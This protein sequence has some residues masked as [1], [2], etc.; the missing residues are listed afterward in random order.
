MSSK[1]VSMKEKP[2]RKLPGL[3]SV[4]AVYFFFLSA[5]ARTFIEAGET[6]VVSTMVMMEA[7]FI[8][9]MSAV[10]WIRKLPAWLQH[11]LLVFQVVLVVTIQQ[12][13]PED[14]FAN[15]LF[16]L[17]S[18]QVALIFHG[19]VL[20]IWIIGLISTT[21]ISLTIAMGGL[22]GLSKSFTNIAGEVAIFAYFIAIR[23]M[24]DARERR[25]LAMEELQ[26]VHNRLEEYAGQVNE[27]SAVNERN[28][29]ARELHDSVSQTLFSISLNIRTVQILFKK[30]PALTRE[31]L[32]RL[33][34]LT[35][36]ALAE[37]RSL[38][39]QMRPQAK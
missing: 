34:L 35:E 20:A 36:N 13:T 30:N 2:T 33:Q 5:V 4:I 38:I 12:L 39:T 21:C 16:V 28:R 31:P 29:L 10:I 8:V 3:I 24:D 1:T 11:L 27:L 9:C 23:E 17:I 37:I 32:H 19:R 14:D 18:Y 15:L 7:I 26:G 22:E 25:R 6:D